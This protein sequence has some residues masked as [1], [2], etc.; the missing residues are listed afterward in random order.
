VTL[1]SVSTTRGAATTHERRSSARRWGTSISKWEAPGWVV[2]C[3]VRGYRGGKTYVYVDGDFGDFVV[4]DVMR[5]KVIG[6]LK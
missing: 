4:W 1:F 2:R 3:F 6:C 5:R